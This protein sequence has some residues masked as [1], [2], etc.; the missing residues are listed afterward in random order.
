MLNKILLLLLS[1]TFMLLFFSLHSVS[2]KPNPRPGELNRVSDYKKNKGTM[3]N[4]ESL[5]KDKAVIAE[6]VKNTR[7]FLGHDL[8]FP[9]PY[10]EYKEVKSEFINKKTADKFKDKRLDVFGIPYFY[11][12][13]V[14][15]NES[16]EEFI[17]DGVCIY[18]GVTMH[19]TAD[20]ISKNIIVPVTVD[21]KQQFSFTISTNKKTVTVQEL[22]YKVR[23]WLTN[24]KKLYEFDGSAY[25]TGY[26][27]FIEENKDSF[28]Y[29]LF[30]K[31]DL[32][33]FIP[34]KFVNIYGDNKT[35]DASSVKIEVHLTTT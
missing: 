5:Y 22:D 13:L 7:Q 29:D 15:K 24:N 18:G 19:S 16:R 34:Y 4:V 1:V 11:T 14:P 28:W 21:N 30:P 12:C 2:A 33:P 25:E 35:I 6:N 10:S 26:I 17:F 20:S 31:K 32:V 23:N 9:I 3:G 27:K 8:I